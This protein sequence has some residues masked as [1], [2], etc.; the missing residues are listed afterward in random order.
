MKKTLKRELK[1]FEIVESDAFEVSV[2]LV[3]DFFFFSMLLH[4]GVERGSVKSKM[5]GWH[6]LHINNIIFRFP[7]QHFLYS[8]REVGCSLSADQ[9]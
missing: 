7:L 3:F 9:G 8:K 5:A 1:A 4:K 2:C 6:Q